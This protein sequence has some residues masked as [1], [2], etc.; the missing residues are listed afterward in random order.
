MA[1]K[2]SHLCH[3]YKHNEQNKKTMYSRILFA[4]ALLGAANALKLGAH[5]EAE[6]VEGAIDTTD[7]VD[8]DFE[9]SVAK[10]GTVE[11]DSFGSVDFQKTKDI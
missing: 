5:Q 8:K 11:T 2:R 1:Y 3:F 6:I 9:V 4:A 10:E 7:Q